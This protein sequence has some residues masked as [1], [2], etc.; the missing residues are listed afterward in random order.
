MTSRA[1]ILLDIKQKLDAHRFRSDPERA[2]ALL[3][4]AANA[5][6]ELL[7]IQ[8]DAEGPPTQT[9]PSAPTAGQE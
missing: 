4:W 3:H 8:V 7:E 5:V 1:A 2:D 9:M 6:Q